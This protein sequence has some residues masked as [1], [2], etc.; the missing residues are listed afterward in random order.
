[1]AN[2]AFSKTATYND[3]SVNVFLKETQDSNDTGVY[4]STYYVKPY[5]EATQL[6]IFYP[7][8]VVVFEIKDNKHYHVPMTLSPFGYSTYRGH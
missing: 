4:Q 6:G 3:G 8:L 7:S 2:K 5:F 1:M